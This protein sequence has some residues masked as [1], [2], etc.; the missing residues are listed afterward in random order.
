MTMIR[1]VDMK[2]RWVGRSRMKVRNKLE[3]KEKVM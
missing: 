3:E 1:M 2:E